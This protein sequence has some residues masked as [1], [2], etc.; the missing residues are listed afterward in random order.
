MTLFIFDEVHLIG[1][2]K[3]VFEVAMSRVRMMQAQLENKIRIVALSASL[4]N[5]DDIARWLGIE[6]PQ[7]TFNFDPSER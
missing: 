1:E 5:Y 2:G 7:N 4:A 3:E 6:F